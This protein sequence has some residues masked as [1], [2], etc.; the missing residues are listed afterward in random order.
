M[1]DKLKVTEGRAQGT[2]LEVREE[3]G[4]GHTL[5]AIIYD[6]V[7]KAEDTIVIGGKNGPHRHEDTRSSNAAAP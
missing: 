7:L 4:L 1:Q 2:V 5:N 6:G 3:V